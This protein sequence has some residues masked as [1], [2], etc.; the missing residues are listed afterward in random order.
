M[1][2]PYKKK[3]GKKEVRK[4]HKRRKNECEKTRTK[5]Q[6]AKVVIIALNIC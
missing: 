4:E 2:Q 5:I 6:R 1:L 3:Q